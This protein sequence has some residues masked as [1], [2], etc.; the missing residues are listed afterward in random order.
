VGSAGA[1]GGGC[2]K[3]VLLNAVHEAGGCFQTP[4]QVRLTVYAGRSHS[5]GARAAG[6]R[7]TGLS[8]ASARPG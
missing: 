6:E 4:H 3:T 7:E 8:R 5:R 2:S 1:H